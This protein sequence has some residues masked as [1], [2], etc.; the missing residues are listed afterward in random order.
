MLIDAQ[1]IFLLDMYFEFELYFW[2]EYE[3]DESMKTMSLEGMN[4]CAFYTYWYFVQNS[5]LYNLL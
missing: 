4:K 5:Y 1:Y 2:Q 3:E